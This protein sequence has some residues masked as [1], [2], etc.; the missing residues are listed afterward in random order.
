MLFRG[1]QEAWK[2]RFGDLVAC[3]PLHGGRAA[4]ATITLSLGG[5]VSSFYICDVGLCCCNIYVR[6]QITPAV[7]ATSVGLL[8]DV[9]NLLLRL[10]PAVKIY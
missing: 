4:S 7:E 6:P 9:R 2:I 10:W 5:D 3:A 1:V 8:C